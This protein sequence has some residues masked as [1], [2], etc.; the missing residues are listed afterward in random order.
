MANPD[1]TSY[2]H[3]APGQGGVVNGGQSVLAISSSQ[4]VK[5]GAGDL[6]GIFTASTSGGTIQLFDNTAAGGT[7][8]VTTFNAVLGWTPLPLF[9]GTGLYVNL[10]GSWWGT[11][12]YN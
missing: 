3:P 12:S 6:V 2:R 10:G 1:G 8:L 4:L 5:S 11:L 9:F 7:L